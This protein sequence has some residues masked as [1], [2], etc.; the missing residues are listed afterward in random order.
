MITVEGYNASLHPEGLRWTQPRHSIP[1]PSR[2]C[3]WA[4]LMNNFREG[5]GH[6]TVGMSH[7]VPP[8]FRR[9]SR[10]FYCLQLSAHLSGY[11]G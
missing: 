5:R 7:T 6:R 8:R 9:A 4:A 11:F 1:S 10:S 3:R 2:R